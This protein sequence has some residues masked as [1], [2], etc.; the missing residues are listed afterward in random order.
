[1]MKSLHSQDK[2]IQEI[3][4]FRTH[5]RGVKNSSDDLRSRQEDFVQQIVEILSSNA[6]SVDQSNA[7]GRP[8]TWLETDLV[9]AM[10]NCPQRMEDQDLARL[11]MS[12]NRLAR[13]RGQFFSMFRY[14]S[15][16]DREFGVT[17]AH[18]ETLKW[19][20]KDPSS[21]SHSW[22]NFRRWLESEDQLYWITGKMGSG[23][24]TLM[25]YIS[26]E[27]PATSAAGGERRCTS[28]L[29]RS[30][31]DRPLFIATFYFWA[32][33]TQET[34]I[35][36]SV[37]GMYRTLLNQILEA[38][39]EAAP[40]VS[41]R[42]WENLC[43]FNTE[44]KPPGITE[45]K[46]MMRKAIEY[47]TSR[48]KACLF[49]DGLDEFEGEDDDL[50]GLITWIKTLIQTSTVKLC[51][52]SRPWRVFED[53]LQDRPHLL[54]ED[55]NFEDIRQY[56]WR[57]FHDDPNFR[58][59]KQMEDTF[60][61]QLL[62]EIVT[63]AEGVFL[64]AYL[65]CTRLLQAM[66]RGDLIGDL[67]KILNSLPVQMEKLYAHILDNLDLKDHAAKYFLLLQAC[68]EQ[69]E[70][71]IFS[72][73]DDVGDDSEFS[74]KRPKQ[75]L[76]DAELLYR[77]TELKKRLNSRCRGIL[78]LSLDPGKTEVPMI[79]L[80]IGTVQYCHRSAKDYLE[81][82]TTQTKLIRMLNM[83]FDP[84]LRLCSAYLARLKCC[85]GPV[86]R[87]EHDTS[88]YACVQHAAKVASESNHMM[89]RI[90]DDVRPAFEARPTRLRRIFHGDPWF[91]GNFLALTVALGVS[92]YVKCKVGQG[93]GCVVRS[94][95][96]NVHQPAA[97]RE[98]RNLSAEWPGIK[99]RSKAHHMED[100][101]DDKE[102]EWPLLL[103]ALLSGKKPNPEMVALL[104]ECGA[105]PNVI[106]RWAGWKK[107]A[108]NA[109][110]FRLKVDDTHRG[111]E[112]D[113]KKAWVDSL[114]LLLRHGAKPEKSDLQF[115]REFIG[116]EVVRT[117]KLPHVGSHRQ[118]VSKRTA[119]FGWVRGIRETLKMT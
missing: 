4:E 9:N 93:R 108:L 66:S 64:W 82:G 56:V 112:P 115:L 86:S 101:I 1:M 21:E 19:I 6:T 60:C 15:M 50:Q 85:I 36:T 73:A 54:M 8:Q 32:G 7:P 38:Y 31:Q 37:E 30:A 43:L 25:K 113:T 61:T 117:L 2:I 79:Q 53:A 39:P 119:L 102:T 40:H 33:S 92:E 42:R 67:R 28:Y 98:T 41:P 75:L 106:I 109:V 58:A 78:C 51:V 68:L 94:S 5:D 45:L 104:L 71:L 80:D 27:L 88:I 16:L 99:Q 65:V 48:A 118:V 44:P 35:Q 22:G 20:F 63:K 24:S 10:Q 81:M 26:E 70:G 23:K 111:S 52:A 77:A 103:D 90:L 116:E 97:S 96:F 11:Q 89:I 29:L 62:D 57:R 12:P 55:F 17:E 69:P 100:F 14:D 46:V 107:S 84:Y 3:S 95:S 59:K 76:T 110:L 72:F 34:R 49:I 74:F 13:V 91:G 18:P 105:D 114:C 87:S 47:V 83:P